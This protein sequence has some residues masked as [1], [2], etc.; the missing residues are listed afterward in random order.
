MTVLD[1]A[2]LAEKGISL[3]KQQD[4]AALLGGIED[5]AQVFLGLADVFADDGAEVNPVEI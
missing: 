5:L 3:V 1:L 2:A 4:C